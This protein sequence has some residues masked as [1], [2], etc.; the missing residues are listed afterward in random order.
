[1]ALKN[2]VIRRLDVFFI[3][4]CLFPIYVGNISV[5][6]AFICI[7]IISKNCNLHF[8]RVQL[9][10]LFILCIC[11]F[12]SFFTWSESWNKIF[13]YRSFVSFS[14]FLTP[15]IWAFFKPDKIFYEN[16]ILAIIIFCLS[17][18]IYSILRTLYE[19]SY[20]GLIDTYLLKDIVGGNR[21]SFILVIGYYLLNYL[22]L[23]GNIKISIYFIVFLGIVLTFSRA[24]LI[25]WLIV[26]LFNLKWHRI[27]FKLSYFVYTGA[28]LYLFFLLFPQ[29]TDIFTF[30]YDR[31]FGRFTNSSYDIS[32][33]TTSEGIRIDTWK[34]ML[35][36]MRENMKLF[37]GT[38]YL[39]PWILKDIQ[40]SS[41]HNQFIDVFFRSGIV[42]FSLIFFT[43]IS[44]IINLFRNNV[45]IYIMGLV[46]LVYGLFHETFKETQGAL[47]LSLLLM[48][49]FDVNSIKKT[50][51]MC[52]KRSVI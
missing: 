37:F 14:L 16:V 39:G 8:G 43:V 11:Y 17:Y 32:K 24:A 18:S 1:M 3:L 4:F 42:G 45:T 29:L 25:T 33:S 44:T 27:N 19:I 23:Q 50:K 2:S 5:N 9:T 6:Y 40:V 30:F 28:V 48:I 20:N 47:I 35:N 7:P 13:V 52:F 46:L 34:S 51:N 26:G 31:I 12:L 38:S 49:Y 10:Y 22:K 21:V 41:S 36:Y 15:F